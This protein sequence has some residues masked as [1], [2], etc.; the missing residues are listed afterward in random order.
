VHLQSKSVH[1]ISY[2][3]LSLRPFVTIDFSRYPRS[4]SDVFR[5]KATEFRFFSLYTGPIAL[6]DVMKDEVFK[7]FLCLHVCFRIMLTPGISIE[8]IDYSEK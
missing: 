4:F 8:L 5:W 3:H 1:V 2:N 7:H 6:K